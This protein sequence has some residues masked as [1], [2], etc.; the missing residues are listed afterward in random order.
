MIKN[1]HVQFDVDADILTYGSARFVLKGET[2]IIYLPPRLFTINPEPLVKGKFYH[3]LNHE[4]AI[5]VYTGSSMVLVEGDSFPTT[6]PG[7]H[8]RNGNWTEVEFK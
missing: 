4:T 3:G 5:W 1:I 6:I 7:A 8:N 2:S